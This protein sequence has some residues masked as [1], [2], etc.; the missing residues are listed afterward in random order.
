MAP[1]TIGGSGGVMKVLSQPLQ[2]TTVERAT[3][4]SLTKMKDEIEKNEKLGHSISLMDRNYWLSGPARRTINDTL[5][6]SHASQ[7]LLAQQKGETFPLYVEWGYFEWEHGKFFTTVPPLLRTA[8]D[9]H[10]DPMTDCLRELPS[11]T[12]TY[13][14]QDNHGESVL[15]EDLMKLFNRTTVWQSLMENENEAIWMIYPS[16]SPGL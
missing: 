5:K 16:D 8:G 10:T 15:H 9:A 11:L 6:R 4:A 13:W 14:E 3:Y 12:Y 7:Q 2:M 1:K